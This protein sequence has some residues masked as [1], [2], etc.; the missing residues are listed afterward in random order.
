MPQKP[1]GTPIM[2]AAR[3]D[4]FARFLLW[5]PVVIFEPSPPAFAVS[6]IRGGAVGLNCS[7]SPLVADMQRSLKD[8]GGLSQFCTTCPK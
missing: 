6:V 4:T 8:A 5:K 1:P 7:R 2:Q 3:A